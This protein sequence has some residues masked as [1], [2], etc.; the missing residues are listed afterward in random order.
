M[1]QNC[2]PS[3]RF[4]M[5][6]RTD[7]TT[8]DPNVHFDPQ[9]GQ[10]KYDYDLPA[11]PPAPEIF[12]D[13]PTAELRKLRNDLRSHILSDPTHTAA[14]SRLL[15]HLVNLDLAHPDRQQRD[16]ELARQQAEQRKE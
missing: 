2:S 8:D 3:W 7:R 10:D 12:S 4:K 14:V 15:G 13:I 5:P 6:K 16:E 9:S 1:S 11:P